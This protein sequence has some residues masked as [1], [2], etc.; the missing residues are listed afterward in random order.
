MTGLPLWQS[1]CS[2][3]E[4]SSSCRELR[5]PAVANGILPSSSLQIACISLEKQNLELSS[6]TDFFTQTKGEALLHSPAEGSW[7]VQIKIHHLHQRLFGANILIMILF[8]LPVKTVWLTFSVSKENPPVPSWG[9]ATF[10][11]KMVLCGDLFS[12]NMLFILAI[13]RVNWTG[14]R[15]GKMVTQ[16]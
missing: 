1:G 16:W 15:D 14:N 11:I 4:Q 12:I 6:P 8:W 10:P 3:W 2:L 5:A 9:V 7:L 13:S